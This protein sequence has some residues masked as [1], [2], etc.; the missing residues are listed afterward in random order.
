MGAPTLVRRG[1]DGFGAD[2]VEQAGDFLLVAGEV[3]F[4]VPQGRSGYLAG[5]DGG[6]RGVE[7][8]EGEHDPDGGE[9]APGVTQTGE[10]SGAG[11]QGEGRTRPS[12]LSAR[13]P[14]FSCTVPAW[15]VPASG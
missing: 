2:E 4:E 5:V 13:N 12:I 6:G 14:D 15:A 8:E 9:D 3:V 1:G 11:I 10:R 7:M